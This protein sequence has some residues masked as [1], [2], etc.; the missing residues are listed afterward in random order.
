M[1]KK[2]TRSKNNRK[3]AGVI[4]GLSEYLGLNST[5][6]RVLFAVALITSGVFPILILYGLLVFILPNSSE[7]F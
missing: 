5:V 2:L 6:L 4:G 1:S 3:L 7:S